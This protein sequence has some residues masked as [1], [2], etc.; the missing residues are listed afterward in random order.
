[1]LF[2]LCNLSLGLA[3]KAKGLARLRAKRKPKSHTACSRSIGKCEGM[4]PH[5]PKVTPTLGDGVTRR[6]VAFFDWS[7]RLF[8]SRW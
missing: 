5:T 3:T 6:K 4:N 1:M 2:L 7:L 8:S